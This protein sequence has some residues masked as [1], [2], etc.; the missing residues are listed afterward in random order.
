VLVLDEADQLMD[1]GFSKDILKITS[2]LPKQERQTLLF[3][4]TM[5]PE[6]RSVMASA[7]DPNF[8]TIDW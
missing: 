1:Q 5:P 2:F 3:S 8:V 6:L 7:M 4:A